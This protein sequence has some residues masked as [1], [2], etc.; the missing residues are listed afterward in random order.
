VNR[1]D[2]FAESF[3]KS[4][5]VA[6]GGSFTAT[7]FRDNAG[8]SG[9]GASA[10]QVFGPGVADYRG[11]EHDLP[12]SPWYTQVIF[13]D[14]GVDENNNAVVVWAD[15]H[16]VGDGYFSPG[17]FAQRYSSAGDPL[18]G[19]VNIALPTNLDD[20]MYQPAV[21]SDRFGN[22]VVVYQRNQRITPAGEVP[23]MWEY[24]LR[25]QGYRPDWTPLVAEQVVHAVTYENAIPGGHHPTPS[26]SFSQPQIAM[27]DELVN[28]DPE[29]S[30]VIV[31]D[32]TP[33]FQEP[34]GI[35]TNPLNFDVFARKYRWDGVALT[36]VTQVNQLDNGNELMSDVSMA[37]DGR[38][39]VAWGRVDG[40]NG[41]VYE[42]LLFVPGGPVY[43][44]ETLVVSGPQVVVAPGPAVGMNPLT[45]DFVVGWSD[46]NTVEEPFDSDVKVRHY[47]P[48]NVPSGPDVA[49]NTELRR[50]ASAPEIG[51]SPEGT[52]VVMWTWRFGS[53]EF[54]LYA[55]R[56]QITAGG[57]GGFAPGGNSSAIEGQPLD[58]STIFAEP[59]RPG[60]GTLPAP[61]GDITDPPLAV[62]PFVAAPAIT[63]NR[64]DDDS[65][66]WSWNLAGLDE[67]SIDLT[68]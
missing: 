41:H 21:A 29:D 61:A 60:G 59:S 53:F 57:S 15:Q 66:L 5:D 32:M 27:T 16:Y 20:A 68:L 25:F 37:D 38:V 18:S 24:S 64:T 47:T 67:L 14:V 9:L 50:D 30:F 3:V 43:P 42:R 33:L 56:L 6:P 28:P 46:L 12:E 26:H 49:V 40:T 62:R 23:E 13:S 44:V 1:S 11:A 8:S 2:D 17:I 54:D 63:P 4:L 45:G 39:V 19:R 31:W 22:F 51:V 58:G 10:L 7:W 52:V 48:T 35:Y 34:S 65:D 36:G 55:R